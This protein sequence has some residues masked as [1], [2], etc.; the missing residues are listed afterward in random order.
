MLLKGYSFFTAWQWHICHKSSKC[1]RM[2][3]IQDSLFSST[4]L[5]ILVTTVSYLTLHYNFW[6]MVSSQNYFFFNIVWNIFASSIFHIHLETTFQLTHT[7]TYINTKYAQNLRLYEYLH[8]IE[9]SNPWP[10]CV[11]PQ[12]F[13]SSLTCLN[14]ILQSSMSSYHTSTC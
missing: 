6:K 13:A 9:Y 3:L 12:W 8:N 2:G 14:N 5:Y 1:T 7:H 4:G 11:L 10:R